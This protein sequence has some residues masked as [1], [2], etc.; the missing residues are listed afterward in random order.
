MPMTVPLKDSETLSIVSI[1]V[2]SRNDVVLV[3]AF[4]IRNFSVRVSIRFVVAMTRGYATHESAAP[5]VCF[6]PRCA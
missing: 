3:T 6:W 5:T 4:E 2:T 1:A